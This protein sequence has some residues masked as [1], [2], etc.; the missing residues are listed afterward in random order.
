[1]NISVVDAS[2]VPLK[3]VLVVVQNLNDREREICRS[4]TDEQG[5]ACGAAFSPGL[6]R[7]IATTPYG[8]WNTTAVEFLASRSVSK[9]TLTMSPKGTHGY[10]DVVTI[11]LAKCD[12][13]VLQSDGRPA[14]GAVVLVRDREVTLFLERSYRTDA[15]GAARIELVGTPTVVVVVFE[16]ILVSQ[17]ISERSSATI[18]IPVQQAP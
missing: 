14:V 9:I 5:R 12:L 16:G 3:D 4:L 17:E 6:Y 10:G 2:G 7:A 8:L 18:R 1:M 15:A 13:Q 11:G